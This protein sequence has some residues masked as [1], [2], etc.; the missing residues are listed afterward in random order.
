MNRDIHSKELKE[1]VVYID[2]NVVYIDYN[3]FIYT[4]A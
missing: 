4:L 2:Y 3:V 1:L